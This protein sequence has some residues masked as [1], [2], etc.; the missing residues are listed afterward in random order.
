M[1]YIIDLLRRLLG[2]APRVQ[3]A[4]PLHRHGA[5]GDTDGEANGTGN[6][7]EYDFTPPLPTAPQV[8]LPPKPS[9][10][11]IRKDATHE[12]DLGDLPS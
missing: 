6:D 5:E 3:A 12:I 4:P 1:R 8:H 9:D 7:D 11:P 2:L 10:V